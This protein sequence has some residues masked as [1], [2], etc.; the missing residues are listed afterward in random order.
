MES[1][2]LVEIKKTL[3]MEFPELTEESHNLVVDVKTLSAEKPGLN[4]WW[5]SERTICRLHI[6]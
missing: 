3:Q 6:N 2:T 1:K 4:P 5:Q